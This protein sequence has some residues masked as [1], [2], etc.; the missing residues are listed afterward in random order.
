[1]SA[2]Y[3]DYIWFEDFQQIKL[4][5]RWLFLKLR[6]SGLDKSSF[7]NICFSLIK[8]RFSITINFSNTY[9]LVGLPTI[10]I[11]FQFQWF[12]FNYVSHSVIYSYFNSFF[13]PSTVCSSSVQPSSTNL[14]GGTLHGRNGF[15]PHRPVLPQDV[16]GNGPQWTPDHPRSSIWA[17]G[18][19]GDVIQGRP[20]ASRPRVAQLV[21]PWDD[22]GWSQHGS[23]FEGWR[24]QESS[25]IGSA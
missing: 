6:F 4:H 2:F 8:V 7:F 1:M 20:S 21:Q 24:G 16:S 14:H 17:C 9:G 10:L 12:C 25:G 3:N 22:P 19:S 23:H 15:P 13:S 5:Q 11:N 18:L